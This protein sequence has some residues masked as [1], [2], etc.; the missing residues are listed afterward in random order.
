MTKI[1]LNEVRGKNGLF[2]YANLD[3]YRCCDDVN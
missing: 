2:I 1:N 3:M